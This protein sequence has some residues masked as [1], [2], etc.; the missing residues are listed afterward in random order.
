MIADP[1]RQFTARFDECEVIHPDDPEF[2]LGLPG[3]DR[4]RARARRWAET[5]GFS[6]LLGIDGGCPHV[7]TNDGVFRELM[8]CWVSRRDVGVVAPLASHLTGGCDGY[9][10]ELCVFRGSLDHVSFWVNCR[11]PTVP[12]MVWFPYGDPAETF[13]VLGTPEYRRELLADPVGPQAGLSIDVRSPDDVSTQDDPFWTWNW[14]G[15]G[16]YRVEVAPAAPLGEH[17]ARMLRAAWQHAEVMAQL[18]S[19]TAGAV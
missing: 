13:A 8:R 14:Y 12:F 3:D 1:S 10:D 2:N 15:H 16:S 7:L 6:R 19:M 11:W 4:A 9:N 17:E 18:R 5:N